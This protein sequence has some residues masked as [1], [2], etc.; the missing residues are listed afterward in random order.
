MVVFEIRVG[1]RN[2]RFVRSG[3]VVLAYQDLKAS[4]GPSD[5]FAHSPYRVSSDDR[6]DAGTFECALDKLRIDTADK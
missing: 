5:V 2:E 3:H 1:N 4:T 6:F